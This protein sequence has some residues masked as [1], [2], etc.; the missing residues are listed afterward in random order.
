MRSHDE[1]YLKAKQIAKDNGIPDRTFRERLDRGWTLE[2]ACTKTRYERVMGYRESN[3]RTQRWKNA[4][5]KE[6]VKKEIKERKEPKVYE[7]KRD[8]E[9]WS[10]KLK[11]Y[12][13]QDQQ[14]IDR[15]R[16]KT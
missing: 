7:P 6:K 2:E 12:Y 3:H 15:L 1:A 11:R 14:N 10:E 4:P 5:R 13:E 8:S 9:S 16:G